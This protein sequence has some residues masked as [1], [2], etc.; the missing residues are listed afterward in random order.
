MGQILAKVGY[1]C[2]GHV[3][4]ATRGNLVGQYV[5]YTAPKT[6][7]IVKKTMGSVISGH[8]V[9]RDGPELPVTEGRRGRK[10]HS[11]SSHPPD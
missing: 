10:A 3:V 9:R 4:L 2:R 5:G 6:N 1:A 11:P 8:P 7:E